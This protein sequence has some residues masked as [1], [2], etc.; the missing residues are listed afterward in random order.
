MATQ[1]TPKP[2][3][4]EALTRANQIRIYRV[5]QLRRLGKAE[6]SL[7]QILNDPNMGA[8]E[9]AQVLVVLPHQRAV[10]KAGHM[11][12]S[13]VLARNIIKD[14]KL[15]AGRQIG[16]LTDVSR[17]TLL[18]AAHK[19]AGS[20]AW[21]RNQDTAPVQ[22]A[23]NINNRTDKEKSLKALEKANAVRLERARLRREIRSGNMDLEQ[24]LNEPA[25][26]TWTLGK[27]VVELRRTT[28]D[29]EEYLTRHSPTAAKKVLTTNRISPMLK[30]GDLSSNVKKLLVM[31]YTDERFCKP[32]R[33]EVAA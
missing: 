5:N 28:T 11:P 33:K 7:E 10:K 16:T 9:I 24:A 30:V 31:L 26:A 6:A 15:S 2:Q 3:H 22:R 13:L 19:Q 8:V 4:M 14:S 12:K 21:I 23:R 20:F 27:L 32:A 17:T 25:L 1:A 18:D 29:G